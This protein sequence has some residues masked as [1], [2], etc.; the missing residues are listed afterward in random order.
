VSAARLVVIQRGHYPRTK[1]PTGTAG[2]DSDP[3]EQEFAVAAASATARSLQAAGFAVRTINADVPVAQY[4]GWA[5]VAIHCDGSVHASARGASVGY[6]TSEG[7]SLGASWKAAYYKAGWR[8]FRSDN[9][10]AALRGYYGVR[11]A[12]AM[13]NRRA[14]I[15]ES[16]FL[17]NVEDERTLQARGAGMVAQAIVA[18][19]G[20]PPAAPRPP[21]PPVVGGGAT[22]R[23]G[24][25][26]DQVRQWQT[27]L[28]GAGHLHTGQID[29]QF[30][31]AT[32]AATK[33]FQSQLSVDPDGVV[34]PDTRAATARLLAWLAAQ[35]RNQ[36][37]EAAYPG[38][39]AHG[40]T[41]W[42]VRV[43]QRELVKRGY[44]LTVDGRFGDAT[45]RSIVHWQRNHG[46]APDGIAGP[47]TWHSL[48]RT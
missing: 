38:V 8:G 10:T 31:P 39:V 13:G 4:G 20:G 45:H 33:A 6:Q 21:A 30:G 5:F 3:T 32:E 26:G 16:G 18:A 22:L 14:I 36:P 46:L 29:G 19:L 42:A 12:V 1:G 7:A 37:R 44:R 28:V 35:A 9:Y 47:K 23:R 15:V 34:G 40:A 27:I 2:R 24:S 43:W 48:L 11:H 17:T 25:T 41:G